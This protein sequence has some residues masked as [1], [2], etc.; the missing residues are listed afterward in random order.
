[1]EHTT[2]F[3]VKI[4][5][6]VDT[7]L[8]MHN[9][10]LADPLNTHVRNIKDISGKRKKTE[11]DHAQIADLEFMGGLYVDD[12]G[13]ITI[14]GHVIEALIWEGA[15]N[16]K[17]GKLCLSGLYVNESSIKM[18]FDGPKNPEERMKD[19]NCRLVAGVKVGASRVMRC[20]P[21]FDNWVLEFSVNVVNSIVPVDA[22]PR[23]MDAAGQLKGLCDWRPRHGRFE[24]LECTA[25]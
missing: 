20:R 8:L 24:T 17:E 12:H 16:S 7:P 22:L 2:T 23:W 19:P 5:A 15:K 25:I 3:K 10:Q 18:E 13:E 4:A 14:P 11:A 9:G 21:R 6:A 1:M